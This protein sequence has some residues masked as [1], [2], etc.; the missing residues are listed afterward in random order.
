MQNA[1][2][3][4]QMLPVFGRGFIDE[5]F[6]GYPMLW[7]RYQPLWHTTDMLSKSQLLL[8]IDL[9]QSPEKCASTTSV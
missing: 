3:M 7:Q 5:I 4:L 1:S 6:C 2:K 9:L 8:C